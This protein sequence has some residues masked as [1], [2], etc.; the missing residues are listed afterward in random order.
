[1]LYT[2]PPKHLISVTSSLFFRRCIGILKSKSQPPPPPP[3]LS[4]VR[5]VNTI[6]LDQPTQ[7]RY[8]STSPPCTQRHIPLAF[9]HLHPSG[10]QLASP[11][12]TNLSYKHHTSSSPT[13]HP[14]DNSQTI[15]RR[16][17]SPLSL[18]P[19]RPDGNDRSP[20]IPAVKA[21]VFPIAAQK[22][23]LGCIVN[24]RVRAL[25]SLSEYKPPPPGLNALP[26]S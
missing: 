21:D 8:I 17:L 4:G 10:S 1:M 24:T 25:L 26:A 13:T 11:S 5:A 20:Q 3:H 16:S 15:F 9:T 12:S 6:T 19:C 18:H 7:T 14:T 2:F 23:F 22:T